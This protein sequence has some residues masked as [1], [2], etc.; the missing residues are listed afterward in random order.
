VYQSMIV[1]DN[2]LIVCGGTAGGLS[3]ALKINTNGNM[4]WERSFA[5]DLMFYD[6]AAGK[7]GEIALVGQSKNKTAVRLHLDANGNTL[8]RKTYLPGIASALLS[9]D[10]GG[11]WVAGTNDQSKFFILKTNDSGETGPFKVINEFTNRSFENEL[12]LIPFSPSPSLF[13]DYGNREGYWVDKKNKLGFI[14]ASSIWLGATEF[15]SLKVAASKYFRFDGIEDF[16]SGIIGTLEK[17]MKK[18]WALSRNELNALQQDWADN[19]KLDQPIP[20]DILSWP[21]CGNPHFNQNLDFSQPSLDKKLLPAPF[22]DFNGDSLYNVFDGDLP[23]MKGDQ[24][25]WWIL[26]D[27]KFHQHSFG[28]RMKVELTCSAYLFDCTADEVIRNTLFV[29]FE[30]VNKSGAMLNNMYM[31]IWSDFDLGCAYD[32]YI[33]C[34][35]KSNAYYVYNR[36]TLDQLCNGLPNYKDQ[37]PVGSV[38]MLN[39]N[40][41]YFMYHYATSPNEKATPIQDI[42]HYNYLKGFWRDGNPADP[43]GYSMC[44]EPPL[45]NDLKAIG[46]HG[47]FTMQPNDTFLMQLAYTYHPNIAYPCPDIFGRVKND[48]DALKMKHERALLAYQRSLPAQ[49]LLQ[50]GQNTVLDAA[51]PGATAYNWSNG[52]TT[53]AITVSQAGQYTVSITRSIGCPVVETVTVRSATNLDEPPSGFTTL[54]VYP[55]PNKGQFWLNVAGESA[56]NLDVTVFNTIGQ[57]VHYEQIGFGLGQRHHGLALQQLPAGL[58]TLRVQ[59]GRQLAW[60][61]V[62]IGR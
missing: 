8:W 44:N 48:I 5:E 31:G 15:N 54:K 32:D 45:N 10:D 22:F 18:V 61:K 37:I 59:A 4:I 11:F 25:A 23:L 7:N 56:E 52:A 17:D 47:P 3:K 60:Q 55:N 14:E 2:H 35:P 21:A 46:S 53:A 13:F 24:M 27:D 9:T 26:N 36:D 19:G 16:Q 49:I 20:F 40:L 34:I 28:P 1:E 51:T 43:A 57:I 6:L 58:Y 42:E 39:Q 62:V 50:A 33:G 41:S 30:V 12:T 29:D 38:A